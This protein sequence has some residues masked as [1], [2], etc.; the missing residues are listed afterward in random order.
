MA[1]F[2]RDKVWWMRFTYKGKQIRKST[3]VTEKKLAEKIYC[4]VMTEVSEGKWFEKPSGEN[5]TFKEMMERYN[6]EYFSHLPSSEFCMSYFD[7]LVDFFGNHTLAKVTP[8]LVN[9]FKSKRKSEGIKPA[10]INRQLTIG[11]RAFNIAI[12]EWEWCSEN[13]FAKVSSEKGAGKRTRWLTFEEEKRLLPVCPDWLKDFVVFAAWTGIREGNIINLKRNQADLQRRVIELGG[14][15][16]HR[17]K[18]DDP[19]VIPMNQKAFEIIDRK[20]SAKANGN[21]LFFTSPKGKQIRPNNLRREFRKALKDAG[22]ENFRIHDLRH[23][24]GTRLA[25]SGVDLYTIAKLL[26]QKD[27]RSTQRYAHHCTQSLRRGLNILEKE[28]STILA[29]SFQETNIQ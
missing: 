3:E 13:P 11:K 28:V 9:E 29:Q 22:I 10:T 14:T 27:I 5:V 23:T 19:L 26:G 8:R 4:K 12:R 15:V 16:N 17:T 24:Y 1:L 21:N 2:K 7:G 20:M 6:K 18:N 25:Q